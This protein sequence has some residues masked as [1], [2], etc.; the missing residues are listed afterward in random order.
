M[1]GIQVAMV[2]TLSETEVNVTAFSGLVL[3]SATGEAIAIGG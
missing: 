1:P 3:A 2:F